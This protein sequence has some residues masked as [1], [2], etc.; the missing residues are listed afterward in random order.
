MEIKIYWYCWVFMCTL[1]V[2]GCQPD[3]SSLPATNAISNVCILEKEPTGY[4][5]QNHMQVLRDTTPGYTLQ[6]IL[7]PSL[8]DKFRAYPEYTEPI[9]NYQYYWGKV[10]LENRLTE[11]GRYTEWVLSF[12][13]TWTRLDF[14]I[15]GED[16]SWRQ[17]KN[18]TLTPDRL[19]K[20][21]PTAKGNLVKL[22]LPPPMK[23]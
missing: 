8:Q 5:L 23:P 10:Q 12:T 9:E 2:A 7:Q 1:L 21:A 18:G 4:Q 14:F 19:K 16:G 3:R 11:A 20:F 22:S 13:D 17:E 6:D 15:E